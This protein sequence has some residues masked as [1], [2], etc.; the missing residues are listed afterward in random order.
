MPELQSDFL[1]TIRISV[2][3]LC[4]I[5]HTPFGT[6]HIDMLGEGSFEGSKLRG[7]VIGGMDQKIFRSDGAMNPNVRLVLKT[8]DEA[9]IYMSYT[10]IRHG[11]KEVMER[12]ASGEEVG[13]S[14]YYLRNTPYFETSAPQYDW[15]NRI[16]SVGVGRRMPDHAAYDIFEIL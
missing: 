2:D 3:D 12:I 16:V 10:G 5:G 15:I 9:L 6:R 13:A 7:V 4:D 11:S 14:E 8:D 1:F